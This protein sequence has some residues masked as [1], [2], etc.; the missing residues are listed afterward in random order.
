[1]QYQ[2][3]PLNVGQALGETFRLY[4]SN[5]GR[6]FL[7]VL[8]FQSIPA[9]GS[10]FYFRGI[11]SMANSAVVSADA[12]LP[13]QFSFTAIVFGLV[14]GVAGLLQNIYLTQWTA[15]KYLGEEAE[16]PGP[17]QRMWKKLGRVIATAL[18]IGLMAAGSVLVVVLPITLISLALSGGSGGGFAIFGLLTTLLMIAVYVFIIW[19]MISM[20]YAFPAVILE[21]IGA[22]EA[23]RRSFTLVKGERWKIFGVFLLIYLMVY[24]ASL[25]LVLPVSLISAGNL[26]E[27]LSAGNMTRFG[28]GFGGLGYFLLIFLSPLYTFPAVLL[29]FSARVNKEDLQLSRIGDQW[30]AASNESAEDGLT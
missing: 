2:L 7:I 18:I 3:R 16:A 17:L 12:S 20:T 15:A 23:I 1:M 6:V 10:I 5:F 13:L 4:F 9:L 30:E 29:Y 11:F 22:G 27:V 21:D 25:A 26:T 14:A 24:A 19:L 28:F 8:A